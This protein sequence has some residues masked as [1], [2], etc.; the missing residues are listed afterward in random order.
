MIGP[1]SGQLYAPRFG[2]GGAGIS[3]QRTGT[4]GKLSFV[5]ERRAERHYIILQITTERAVS[6]EGDGSWEAIGSCNA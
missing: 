4:M 5:H 2:V 3:L 1:V 6:Y